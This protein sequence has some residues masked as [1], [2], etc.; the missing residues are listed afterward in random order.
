MNFSRPKSQCVRWSGGEFAMCVGVGRGRRRSGGV[1]ACGEKRR[2]WFFNFLCFLE[3]QI[4]LE[5]FRVAAV[6][7]RYC[8]GVARRRQ[9]WLAKAALCLAWRGWRAAP[10][11]SGDLLVRRLRSLK[12]GGDLSIW[13]WM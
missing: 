6:V 9:E 10:V 8:G 5:I 3:I 4:F 1:E 13:L 11:E 7:L 2:R 12:E